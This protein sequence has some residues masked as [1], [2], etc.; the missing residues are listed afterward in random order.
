MSYTI[1]CVLLIPAE[2]RAEINALAESLGY[3][4]NNLSVSLADSSGNKWYGCHTWCE[5][6]F[7][8]QLNDPIYASDAVSA[9]VISAIDGGD[10]TSNWA[11]ALASNGLSANNEEQPV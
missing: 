4:P 6:V 11:Q 9:L 8:D 3:G 1:S 10:P 5:Q 7:I 2:H